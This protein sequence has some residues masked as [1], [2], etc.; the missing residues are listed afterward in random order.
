MGADD[1][2]SSTD[3]LDATQATLDGLCT[4]IANLCSSIQEQAHVFSDSQK[5]GSD[6][7]TSLR[8]KCTQALWVLDAL[9]KLD[10]T[11]TYEPH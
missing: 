6:L 3:V 5:L 4:D 10:L 2:A 11:F 7:E 1:A 9:R 8:V